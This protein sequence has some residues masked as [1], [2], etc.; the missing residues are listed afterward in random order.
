MQNDDQP[1]SVESTG[2]TEPAFNPSIPGVDQPAST[3]GV[4]LVGKTADQKLAKPVEKKRSIFSRYLGIGNKKNE[5]KKPKIDPSVPEQ[6]LMRWSAPE[7]VQ[8][9]KPIGWYIGFG[10][11]F[12]ALIAIALFT[13]QYLTVG[14]FVV[15]AVAVFIYANRPPRILQYQVSNYGVYVGDKQYLFDSLDVYYET[16]DYGQTVLELVPNTRFGTLVS[17]PPAEH[18]LEQLEQTLGQMLPKVENRDNFV[19]L[20]FRKL[21]F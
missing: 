17:L 15:M 18:Q 1:Q 21:R 7:F 16:S 2:T 11:F 6:F 14:L 3:N 8:T 12:V 20:L 9:H 10:L 4:E 19:D 5:E 13:K